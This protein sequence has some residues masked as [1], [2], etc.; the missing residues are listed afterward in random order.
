MERNTVIIPSLRGKVHI[1]ANDSFVINDIDSLV[2]MRL[3][4]SPRYRYNSTHRTS[5]EPRHPFLVGFRNAQL[6]GG[7][8]LPRLLLQVHSQA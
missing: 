8:A 7:C 3:T 6:Q 1:P 2:C 4:D 5:M